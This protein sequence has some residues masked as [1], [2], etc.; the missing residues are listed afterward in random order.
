MVNP[1]ARPSAPS[2]KFTALMTPTGSFPLNEVLS[3]IGTPVN[4]AN[5]SI[6]R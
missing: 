2:I 1:W 3:T 4:P 5:A 6:S